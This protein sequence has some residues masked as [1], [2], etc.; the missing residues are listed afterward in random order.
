MYSARVLDHFQDPR[1]A[2]EVSDPDAAVEIENPACGDI[3][4]LTLKFS[5][6]RI[7]EIRFKAKGCVPSMACGSALTELVSGKTVDEARK[8]RR[9]DVIAAVGGLPKASSHAA[10]LVLDALSAALK[11]LPA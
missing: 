4:R 11:Q 3:L 2:G 1:N 10:Q 9:E 6:G 8:L 7:S 5:S